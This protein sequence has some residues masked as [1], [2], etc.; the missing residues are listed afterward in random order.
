MRQVLYFLARALQ[1]LGLA[2][3]TLVVMQF[4][5]QEGMESLLI[6]TLLGIGEFY[7][8]TFVLGKIGK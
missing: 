5:T 3:I 2:T 1:V 7:C 6:K 4:F 8:G